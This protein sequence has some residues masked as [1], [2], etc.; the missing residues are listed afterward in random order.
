MPIN[1][2][3]EKEVTQQSETSLS[4]K[5][6]LPFSLSIPAVSFK[7]MILSEEQF[8]QL[9][10]VITL[11][12]KKSLIFDT[13]GLGNVIKHAPGYKV[14]LYGP[15]G[16]G[17]TMAAQAIAHELNSPVVMVDYSEIESKY[18]GE[19]AKNLT[20]LFSLANQNNAVLI[21]DEADA[22]LSKRVTEMHSAADVS[23][24]QTRSVLLKL[25]DDYEGVCIFTTNFLSNYDYAFMRRIAQQ[26][27]FQLP[28]LPQREKL[29]RHYLVS[30]L[31]HNADPHCLAEKFEGISGAD[32]ATAVLSAAVQGAY[33]NLLRIDQS[34]FENAV[35]D[36]LEAR[37]ENTGFIQE[38]SK[39]EFGGNKECLE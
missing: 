12:Q 1:Y 6:H 14:N 8:R 31:P 28:N 7:D 11:V 39:K 9:H 26:I 10:E 32:I 4:Q 23:V 29:W 2:N 20:T 38:E 24:N 13:W 19:T 21:F 27:R 34:Y 22:L 36:I 17:K 30:E 3:R 37:R 15:P 16:T 25:L 18:V 33:L 35:Q 5:D